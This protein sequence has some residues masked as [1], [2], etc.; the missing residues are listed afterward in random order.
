MSFWRTLLPGR[1]R[2]PASSLEV[3]ARLGQ[4]LPAEWS[5]AQLAPSRAE[6]RALKNARAIFLED[7]DLRRRLPPQHH[8]IVSSGLELAADVVRLRSL[9]ASSRLLVT[10]ER[11]P[12]TGDAEAG[13]CLARLELGE[14]ELRV[15]RGDFTD[16]LLRVDDYPT[17]VRPILSDLQPLHDVLLRIDRAGVP[18][19]LGIVPAILEEPMVRF[20]NG[21]EHLIVAQHGFDHGYPIYS[22]LLIEQNDPFNQRGTVKAFDEFA[23]RDY[24]EQLELLRRGRDILQSRL[25]RPVAGYVPPTNTANRSTGRALEALSFEYVLTEQTV[26]GCELPCIPSGFYGRSSELA[27][28]P[29]PD[30]ATLHVTWEADLA[31]SGVDSLAPFL[32]TLCNERQRR[33]DE[34]HRVSDRIAR[35]VPAG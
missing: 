9:L 35:H 23:G 24:E 22:K 20:L 28:G 33:R 29:V 7:W 32:T 2:L 1:P 12:Q 17:G 14:L 18:F 16:P 25:G 4:L 19:H 10:L 5:V 3:L 31:R 34:V 6:R 11:T 27:P 13:R 8:V 21:L 26:P 15:Y 30:V